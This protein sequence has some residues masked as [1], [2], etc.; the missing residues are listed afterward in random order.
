M[1]SLATLASP[2][3]HHAS[4]PQ[5]D[6]PGERT[7]ITRG[8][9]FVVALSQVQPG[10]VLERA[11]QPDESMLLLADVSAR[12]EAGGAKLEAGAESLL[13]IP[14]GSCTITALT[15]GTIVRV[16]SSRA[17]DLLAAAS[18]APV[19]A[20]GAPE[21]A[22]LVPWPEPPDGMRLRHYRLA[23][24]ALPSVHMRIFRCTTLML[25]VMMPRMVA[26]DVTK[27][28]PHQHA[29]FE[30]GSLALRGQ[31]VHH[32]RHPWTADL[33]D[34]KADEHLEMDSP[35]LLVIPPKVIHT[36][37]NVNDGGA[38]LVDV[39]A[40]PR[41]DFSSTPGKVANEADYPLPPGVTAGNSGSE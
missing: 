26:R 36:S 38:W 29:D 12:I 10:T 22:P 17:V 13:I 23:D 30:Q 5:R 41:V 7:W 9:N 3:R 1:P 28:S 2:A 15:A 33:N 19:Y 6:V 34:W 14:P 8:A 39:F 18:N 40:P 4:S 35:S 25:N 32:L 20:R 16:F 31:W 37:R 27:L 21:V 11:Q 24:Y